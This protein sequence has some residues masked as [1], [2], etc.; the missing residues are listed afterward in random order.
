MDDIPDVIFT[1]ETSYNYFGISVAAAGD[2]N[3]D[4]FSDVIIGAE[5][6]AAGGFDAGRAYLYLGGL[7]M[8]NIADVIFTG[9]AG[10]DDFGH[11][12]AA[13]G[14]VNHD[15]FSDVIVGA[16]LND[17]GGNDAGRAYLYFG[18]ASMDNVADVIFTGETVLNRFGISIAAAGDVNHDGFADVLVGAS[19]AG[20]AYLYFGGT[21]M[22]NIAD[23]IFTGETGGSAF[24][25][26]AAAAG[27]V[28]HDGFADV[29]VG[30]NWNNAGGYN[31]GRA[32]L[33]F[34][35]PR[36]DNLAD[37][38]FTGAAGSDLF[39][40]S[41]AAAGDVNHDGF[42][43]VIVGA[44]GNSAVGYQMGRAYVYAGGTTVGVEDKDNEIPAGYHLLQNYP[45]PFN[46]TT[47]IRFS[48]PQ[49]EHVTLKIFDLLGK[50]VGTLVEGDLA[51]GEHAVV[52]AG[53]GLSSGVYLYHFQAGTFV[54]RKKLVLLR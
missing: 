21:R 27:D 16:Y 48:L 41:V 13:A 14:D 11:S 29:I 54:E 33:Y 40:I 46:P 23:V 9:A 25:I 30:D 1:G 4:G 15:G 5:G 31:A 18:G 19:T 7:N 34:G 52:F 42:S 12:V 36:M 50:E 38:V 51:P 20:R 10:F 32:Y 43:D 22:D 37:A 44:T 49:R 47:T 2:V 39:G 8:D 26:S 35:G 45:N 6:N 53:N 28:N 3:Q 17:A 24:G